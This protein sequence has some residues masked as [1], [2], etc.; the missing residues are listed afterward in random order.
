MVAHDDSYP[1]LK[2][3]QE[4]AWPH[5]LQSSVLWWDVDF[6]TINSQYHHDWVIARVLEFGS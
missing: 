6:H 3:A 5:L 1:P 4:A 2:P